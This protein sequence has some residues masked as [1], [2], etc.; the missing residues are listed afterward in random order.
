MADKHVK[1]GTRVEITGK[2][3]Q[4]KI[5]FVGVTSFASGKWIGVILDEAKGKN[6][7]LVQGKKYFTCPDNHGIFVRQSQI[8][9]LDGS[10]ATTPIESKTSGIPKPGGK[11]EKK[12][13]FRSKL[14]RPANRRS[15]MPVY[16]SAQ[17]RR[18]TLPTFKGGLSGRTSPATPPGQSPS[19]PSQSDHSAGTPEGKGSPLAGTPDG[20]GKDSEEI[21]NL[22]C[23]VQDLQEKLDT[24]K[25]KRAEDKSKLKE[26][27]KMKIQYQ[28]L[29]EFKA[30]MV[31]AKT[32]LEKQLLEA[33]KEAREAVEERDR[34]AEEMAGVAETIEMAA[35]DKEMAEEKA[36]SLQIEV[37]QYKDRVEELTLDLELLRSEIEQEGSD[38]AA[39]SYQVKQLEQQNNRLKEAL[40]KLRDLSNDEKQEHQKAMK[41]KEKMGQDIKDLKAQKENTSKAL[42]EAES[43]VIELKEQ[44]DAALGAEEMVESLT[45]QNL[46]LEEKIEKLETDLSDLEALNE[47]NEELQEN[48]RETELELRE[49]L[50]LTKNRV[51]EAKRKIGQLEENITD[52]QE[53]IAKFRQLT[54]TLQ[55][56]NREMQSIHESAKETQETTGVV[57]AYD[58][59]SKMVEAKVQAK[60]IE[61]E[62][63]KL[64]IVQARQHVKFLLSF[65]P[66][67]FMR[68]GGDY[69]CVQV[70]LLIA[71]LLAKSELVI[72]QIRDKVEVPEPLDREQALRHNLG[73]ALS[74]TNHVN[75]LMAKLQAILNK[76]RVAMASCSV[77][78]YCKIGTLYPEMTPH[79]RPLDNIID[80]LRQDQLDETTSLE[81]VEKAVAYFEHLHSVHLIQENMDHTNVMADHVKM[82]TAAAE[83]L[84]LELKKLKVFMQT[85]QETTDFAILLKDLDSSNGD[86]KQF[87]RMIR[88][89]LPTGSGDDQ[90]GPSSI[91]YGVEVQNSISECSDFLSKMV[92][93]MR[94]FGQNAMKT[95]SSLSGDV[96]GIPV[97]Q[98]EE[99]A[100]AACSAVFGKDD[101]G[102]YQSFRETLVK[103]MVVMNNISSAMQNGEYDANIPQEKVVGPV[104]KRALKVKAEICDAEGLGHK[105]ES[106]ENEVKDIKRQLKLKQ[107]EVSAA[108]V[109][110]GLVEKKLENA[111]RDGEEKVHK[112]EQKLSNSQDHMK[113][114]EREFDLTLDHMQNDI[115]ALEKEKQELKQRLTQL[116]KKTLYES[117]TGRPGA[118]S[119]IAA[120]VVGETDGAPPSEQVQVRD[121]PLLL[122]QVES[123]KK[124]LYHVKRE[125]THLRGR[126]MKTIM[127]E[128][129]PLVVP[130]KPVGLM[131]PTGFV[132]IEVENPEKASPAANQLS[133]LVRQSGKLMKDLQELSASPRVVDITHR[134][135]GTIPVLDKALPMHQL[136]ERTSRLISLQQTLAEVQLQTE[137][138]VTRQRPGA[139]TKGDFSKFI[140]SEFAK[141]RDE[142]SSPPCIGR[143]TMPTGKGQEACHIAVKLS[144]P[145]L[146]NLHAK[147]IQ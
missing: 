115:D 39:T 66:D 61:V 53:T 31:E 45:E 87:S 17:G 6:N 60:A 76:Y 108:S 101:K 98:L 84:G 142:K 48:N 30:K 29:Q 140:S 38:G 36:D 69:D 127:D 5:A 37:D 50:D 55:E 71:R 109:R 1:P 100:E 13:E 3:L 20:M 138:L 146:R 99:Y 54:A 27:E 92:T 107:E 57:P 141:V 22:K 77:E 68:R 44:V 147:L 119:S 7:G 4:G 70:L 96:E 130:K 112:L 12:A 75:Y 46:E 144:Q 88:R 78:L 85:N 43:Q 135:P 32:D 133:D 62:I 74:F 23:A 52:H 124:A 58:F 103:A 111:S 139:Q 8:T 19:P 89:R 80:L 25:M 113:K 106:K 2:S 132:S 120:A 131:S 40:V 65:M 35:L 116:S 9:I 56:Q 143:I 59:T 63:G 16:V 104:E 79:E 125:N 26:A 86:L 24:L 11:A 137:K 114:K 73:E 34:H 91:S 90:G 83:L 126:K 28:Q 18:S 122:H 95:A 145:Q 67:N 121:S 51:Q 14:M 117:L 118:P 110:L 94:M 41:D 21:T 136:V 97:K 134:K 102:P 93:A 33:K 42:S 10:P 47:M 105:L 123:L 129:P 82:T 64:E 81:G 128:L 72:L 49:E 15:S